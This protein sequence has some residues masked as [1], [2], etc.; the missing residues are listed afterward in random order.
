MKRGPTLHRDI[1]E[2]TSGFSEE[3][4]KIKDRTDSQT[5]AS[6]PDVMPL[7]RWRRDR[8]RNSLCGCGSG[9]KHK[10]CCELKVLKL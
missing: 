10:D 3:N 4:A 2:I 9:K 5:G 7:W 8:R 6:I 1:R